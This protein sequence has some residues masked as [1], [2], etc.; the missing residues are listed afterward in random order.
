MHRRAA[1]IAFALAVLTAG[2]AGACEMLMPNPTE[3]GYALSITNNTTINVEL[4][5]NGAPMGVFAPGVHRDPIEAALPPLPWHVEARTTQS[6]R[7][8]LA[9]DV[10]LG[11][12]FSTIEPDGVVSSQG[13]GSRADL[14]C[15]RLDVWSG[16]PMLGP[17]PEPGQPG[18]CEP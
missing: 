16:P 11:D 14:S 7:L 9:F 3:P 5:V 6:H 2:S 17:L 13:A 1:C 15:G 12:V 4:R 18:D 8:L 10:R